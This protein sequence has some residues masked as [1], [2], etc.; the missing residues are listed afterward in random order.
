MLKP[1]MGY[2]IG[3]GSENGAV[4]VFA[5]TQK[6]ARKLTFESFKNIFIDEV[7]WLDIGANLLDA[8]HLFKQANQELLVSDIP[9]VID[10]PECC[11]ECFFWGK[12]L[13]E[14]KVCENCL[15]KTALEGSL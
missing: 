15:S 10:E 13:N 9:H 2:S 5:H 11:V 14:N 12:E 7:E 3:A 6:E 1:Y 4:L 8:E